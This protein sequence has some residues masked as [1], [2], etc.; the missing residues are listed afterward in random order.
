MAVGVCDT[1]LIFRVLR[2][3]ERGHHIGRCGSRSPSGPNPRGMVLE[4][5]RRGRQG[6]E[7]HRNWAFNGPNGKQTARPNLAR[8]GCARQTG[9]CRRANH[10]A[11]LNDGRS[12]STVDCRTA[13]HEGSR[14]A[15][16][17]DS[18]PLDSFRTCSGLRLRSTACHADR[19]PFGS[20][21]GHLGLPPLAAPVR[22]LVRRDA[23]RT[24][25]RQH[26]EI[27]RFAL[28]QSLLH[29]LGHACRQTPRAV[30]DSR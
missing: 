9:S 19:I 21:E 5:I 25:R 22:Q 8:P 13:L 28:P 26:P 12:G 3:P 11:W 29:G 27:E 2:G 18:S 7:L 30:S 4:G 10:T 14:T 16:G 17:A 23:L 20:P 24:Q 6:A 15:K 1:I